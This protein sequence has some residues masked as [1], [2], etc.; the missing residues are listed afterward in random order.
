MQ[1]HF[2]AA[3]AAAASC[4][5]IGRSVATTFMHVW[6]TAMVFAPPICRATTEKTAPKQRAMRAHTRFSDAVSW[7]TYTRT[8]EVKLDPLG[9]TNLSL[10]LP[11]AHYSPPAAAADAIAALFVVYFNGK[12]VI[13]SRSSFASSHL[14]ARG[15]RSKMKW[16]RIR[17]TMNGSMAVYA[18]AHTGQINWRKDKR[19]VD[20]TKSR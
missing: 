17:Y 7:A 15:K 18:A 14:Q 3:T 1:K 9:M 13:F 16:K 12:N 6:F 20:K 5:S 11:P 8:F 10:S 19:F 2:S 4:M